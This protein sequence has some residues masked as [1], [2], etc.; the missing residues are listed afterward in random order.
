MLAFALLTPRILARA[1]ARYQRSCSDVSLAAA[2]GLTR[3]AGRTFRA[4][5]FLRAFRASF[6]RGELQN[7]VAH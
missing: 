3:R 6:G 4:F 1:D 7:S 2:A 5:N